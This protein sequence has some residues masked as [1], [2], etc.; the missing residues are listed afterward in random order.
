[1]NLDKIKNLTDANEDYRVKYLKTTLREIESNINDNN[2]A[3]QKVTYGEI[4]NLTSD[5][6]RLKK[7]CVE[8]CMDK[9]R[10][11]DLKLYWSLID[12]KKLELINLIAT[13]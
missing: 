3:K 9:D 6:I 5:L 4:I 10:E 1:M 7:Q 2:G 12:T 11:K 13:L 8:S